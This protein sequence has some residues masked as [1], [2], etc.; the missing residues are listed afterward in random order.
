MLPVCISLVTWTTLSLAPPAAPQSGRQIGTNYC[1][2]AMPNSTGFPGIITATGSVAVLDNDVTL[3]ADQLLPSQFGYFLNSQSPGL[4]NPPNSTGLICLSGS[5]GR[6][7]Q[8]QNIIVG[9]TGSIALDLT[10]LP[11]AAGL[12][13]V[14][15][16]ETWNFQCW[17]RDVANTNNFTDGVSLTFQ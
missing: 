1:G 2:P 10:A 8:P 11:Q 17:Y 15:P 5:I 9:P 13:A 3:T 7:N 6:H 4:F 12:V 16:G 14:Q